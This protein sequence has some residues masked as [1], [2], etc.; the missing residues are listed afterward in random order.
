VC[1]EADETADGSDEEWTVNDMRLGDLDALMDEFRR[2]MIDRY[3][4]EKCAS[5][6]NCKTCDRGCLWRKIVSKAPTIDAVPVVR[7][8]DCRYYRK[9]ELGVMLCYND[10][11][12]DAYA[13]HTN[14]DDFC[15]FGEW[16]DGDG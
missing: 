9:N 3:D 6:E 13:V 2:Y 12:N 11:W 4:R 8:K 10:F 5:E 1:W 7:C 14:A 16:K 15:S